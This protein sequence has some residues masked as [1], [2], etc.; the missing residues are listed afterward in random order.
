MST[1]EE[2]KSG[3]GK[4]VAVFGPTGAERWL[5]A[6]LLR[7]LPLM[8]IGAEE[9]GRAMLRVGLDGDLGRNRLTLENRALKELSKRP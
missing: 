2:D 4:V 8:G 1:T 7:L 6:P 3:H 9:L 5:L